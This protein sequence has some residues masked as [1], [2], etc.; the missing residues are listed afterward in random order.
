M[1][2]PVT[3]TGPGARSLSQSPESVPSWEGLWPH[4]ESLSAASRRLSF[5]FFF[6]NSWLLFLVI[7][8]S[9]CFLIY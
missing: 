9:F 8:F 6:K 1:G 4:P 7:L 5:S 3:P 2:T